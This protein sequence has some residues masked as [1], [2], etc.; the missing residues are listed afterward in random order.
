MGVT[1]IGIQ[2]P[3]RVIDNLS[4]QYYCNRQVHIFEEMVKV[5]TILKREALV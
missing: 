2:S 4:R 5:Y 3:K 1:F